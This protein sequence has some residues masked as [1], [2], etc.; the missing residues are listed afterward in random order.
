[1]FRV[2]Y[3]FDRHNSRSFDELIAG[4][5]ACVR[6]TSSST[7]YQEGETSNDR[8]QS[9]PCLL[10]QRAAIQLGRAH[11]SLYERRGCWDPVFYESRPTDSSEYNF[12]RNSEALLFNS[13]FPGDD[14]DVTRREA[15][16]R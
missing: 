2:E 4:A 13:R 14:V 5:I 7:N 10:L 15:A 11:R 12:R 6:T 1:M 3:F 8:V 9:L 16:V